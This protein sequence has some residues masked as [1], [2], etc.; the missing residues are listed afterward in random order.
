MA[1]LTD[2]IL[3]VLNANIPPP[4]KKKEGKERKRIFP[5]GY[6]HDLLPEGKAQK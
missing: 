5:S 4:P 2:I 3:E 1:N 6:M